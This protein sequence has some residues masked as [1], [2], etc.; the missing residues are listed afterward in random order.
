M[1][2]APDDSRT[3]NGFEIIVDGRLWLDG[4]GTASWTIGNETNDFCTEGL[5]EN[6]NE[7]RFCENST[8]YR[9]SFKFSGGIP[10]PYDIMISGL[11]QIFAGNEILANYNVNAV[12]LGRPLNISLGSAATTG[13]VD[14]ALIE[15]G[16]DYEDLTTQLDLRFQKLFT[17]PGGNMRVRGLHGCGKP[18]QHTHDLHPESVL[19]R[20][21]TL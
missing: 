5:F 19:G 18:V 13:N 9:N 21:T 10:L 17:I 16:T 7:L 4:F 8:G 14:Y 1:T 11:F 2:E 3:W 6:P 15:P 20:R 12:D